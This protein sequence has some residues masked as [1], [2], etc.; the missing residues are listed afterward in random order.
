MSTYLANIHSRVRTVD[1][2]EVNVAP[3]PLLTQQLLPGSGDPHFW[4]IEWPLACSVG[5]RQRLW[6]R[7]V[8]GSRQKPRVRGQRV[9]PEL[10]TGWPSPYLKMD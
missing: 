10:A 3:A 6:G 8:P 5:G 9:I 4:L 7:E 1:L 2:N